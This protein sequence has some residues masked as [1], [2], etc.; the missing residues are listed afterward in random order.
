MIKLNKTQRKRLEDL[1][2][3][4][5]NRG[6]KHTWGNHRF[7]QEL[8]QSGMDD[9]EFLQRPNR[10]KLKEYQPLTDECIAAVD[11]ILK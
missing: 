11:R 6:A 9:R 7:I 3:V 10:L 2:F 5:G 1:W 8:L 4:Y